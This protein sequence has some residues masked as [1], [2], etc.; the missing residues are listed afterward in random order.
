MPPIEAALARA[1]R[2]LAPLDE[3]RGVGL[4]LLAGSSA[5]GRRLAAS[6][7]ARVS[8]LLAGHAAAAFGLAVVAPSFLLA[9]TPLLFGVPHLASGVRHLLI[10]RAWPAWWLGAS[11]AFAVALIALRVGAEVWPASAPSLALEQ[12][13]A[14][15]WVVLGAVAALAGA[16]SRRGWLVLLAA[17]GVAALAVGAPRPFRMIL[18]H[19]HNLV[20]LVIWVVLFRRGRRLILLPAAA[21]LLGALWLATG[22]ALGWTVRHGW[23]TV[24]GLHLFAAADWLAPGLPDQTAVALT[25]AFA[26]LQAVHYAVWLVGIPAGDRPGDGGRSWRSAWRGLVRDFRPGGLVVVVVLT[27][28]VAAAGLAAAAPARRLFLSIGSFHAWLELAALAALLG[29]GGPASR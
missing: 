23:L 29:R 13:L 27:A 14:G 10:R 9:V 25:T 19:G 22:G 12:G 28:G 16:P 20:A 3:L 18:L 1:E 2:A 26:F 5:A 4:R 17:L 8:L 21:M 24:A 7:N 11:A 6:R 15:A